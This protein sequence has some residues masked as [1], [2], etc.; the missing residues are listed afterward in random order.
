MCIC[1]TEK[2]KR[3]ANRQNVQ[4]GSVRCERLSEFHKDLGAGE[5]ASELLRNQPVDAIQRRQREKLLNHLGA[6]PDRKVQR[7]QVWEECV[8]TSVS[9][10]TKWATVCAV[11]AE[12]NVSECRIGC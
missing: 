2:M 4:T 5:K 3:H 12:A 10:V 6:R 1:A 9:R 8:A 11:H 7:V